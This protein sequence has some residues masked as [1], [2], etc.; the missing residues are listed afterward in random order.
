MVKLG[1]ALHSEYCSVFVLI[2][3]ML[4]YIQLSFLSYFHECLKAKKKKKVLTADIF[5]LNS[6]LFLAKLI[7]IG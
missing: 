1:R 5:L 2:T 7:S 4:T 6:D 3:N